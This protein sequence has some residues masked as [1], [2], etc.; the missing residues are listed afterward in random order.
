MELVVNRELARAR[1]KRVVFMDGDVPTIMGALEPDE[2]APVC[3]DGMF[4]C[5][6]RNVAFA[7]LVRVTPRAVF[8][9]EPMVPRSYGSMDPRQR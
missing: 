8:Y 3:T 9:K 4:G 6:G 1:T 7:S 2:A 5:N